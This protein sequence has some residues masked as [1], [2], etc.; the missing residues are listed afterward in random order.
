[1]ASERLLERRRRPIHV[2]LH[3]EHAPRR[4]VVDVHADVCQR[5]CAGVCGVLA[6]L[7]DV[8]DICNERRVTVFA[9]PGKVR[10][11][12]VARQ[13]P[14]AFSITRPNF[15]IAVRPLGIDKQ[16]L[17]DAERT[18]GYYEVRARDGEGGWVLAGD[19]R[20]TDLAR[21]SEDRDAPLVAYVVDVTQG[22][23]DTAH[24]GAAALAYIGMNMDNSPPWRV[25]M[26]QHDVDWTTPALKEALR[27]HWVRFSA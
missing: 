17:V 12:D 1:M 23:Q 7:R 9:P 11:P 20:L 14:S 16:Q 10:E 18:H 8:H 25:S 2:V 26:V 24:P 22:S 6:A 21:W 5:R 3:H 15:V 27:G 13:H 4:R 19:V